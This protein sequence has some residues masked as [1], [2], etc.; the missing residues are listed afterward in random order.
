MSRRLHT[1]IVAIVLSI[2]P[3]LSGQTP[4]GLRITVTLVDA[5]QQATPVPRHA[6]LIS[7]NPS[8]APPRR[9]LTSAEGI[10]DLRLVPGTYTVESDR[11]V[12]FNGRSYQWTQMIEVVAGRQ[13]TLALTADNAEIGAASEAAITAP[14]DAAPVL[15]SDPSF[16]LGLWQDSV[17]TLWTPTSSGAGFVI[18]TKGLIATSRRAIGE[19][20]TVDVQLSPSLKVAGRVL[21]ADRTQD[22]AI[23][24]IDPGVTK[25][26]KPVPL[27][28]ESAS[29]VPIEYKDE[30]FTIV[31]PFN[32]AKTTASGPVTRVSPQA[33]WVDFRLGF[34]GIG[35][36]VFAADGRAVGLSSLTGSAED[37]RQR[38]WWVVPGRAACDAMKTAQAKTSG[39]APPAT[40][41]PVEPSQPF[42]RA[43]LEDAVKRGTAP[44]SSYQMSS[45]DFDITFI[46]PI[47]PH[48]TRER[49]GRF[50][51]GGDRGTPNPALDRSRLLTDFGN[52]SDY[53]A[54]I[55]P[56]L[57]V[58]ATPR[59]VEGLLSKLARGAA[60]TQGAALPAMKRFKPGFARMQAFCGAAEVPPIHPFI[61]EQ[62]LSKDD[63]IREGLYAY[64][65]D[66]LGP[67]CGTVKLVF[68]SEKSPTKGD[69]RVVAPKLLEQVAR[70]LRR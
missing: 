67:Q 69:A 31:A 40:R 11:P 24:W 54:E 38:E 27:A 13:S 8:T 17:V 23:L 5:G 16:L 9:V 4:S 63:A 42:S 14:G 52:W 47:L 43:A 41:L 60:M 20:T 15:E 66:A 35:G 22:V 28:C 57:L 19:A 6:L 32:K 7:D 61:L 49:S 2:S 44:V 45:D 51:R 53:V 56:V 34:D 50:E 68:Y 25:A 39:P 70:D 64:G 21:V 37:G 12:V 55:P 48:A 10:V 1:L 26:L 36:P 65:P 29:A 18:D 33:A 46:T 62:Q 58:R 3:A 30:L 59:F